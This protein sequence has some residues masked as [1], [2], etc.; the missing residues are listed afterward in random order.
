MVINVRYSTAVSVDEAVYHH[1][2]PDKFVVAVTMPQ[3][4][5]SR[6]C[7]PS[8]LDSQPGSECLT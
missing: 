3:I 8:A 6:N 2:P 5:G 1:S 7:V 4:V